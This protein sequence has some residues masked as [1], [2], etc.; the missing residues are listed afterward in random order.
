MDNKKKPVRTLD[1]M[2]T[3]SKVEGT[4]GVINSY[5]MAMVA[6]QCAQKRRAHSPASNTR[7]NS[8]PRRGRSSLAASQTAA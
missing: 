2:R 5:L 6:G 7:I 1:C 4:A 8:Y 3:T